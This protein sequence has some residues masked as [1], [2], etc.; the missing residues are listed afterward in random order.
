MSQILRNIDG[1]SVAKRR[2]YLASQSPQKIGKVGALAHDGIQSLQ[3]FVGRFRQRDTSGTPGTG[4]HNLIPL[5]RFNL[6]GETGNREPPEESACGLRR[7][8]DYAENCVLVFTSQ[9]H[10]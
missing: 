9:T 1:Q 3:T 5:Y 8:K 2:E 6:I 4:Q 10:K 7:V